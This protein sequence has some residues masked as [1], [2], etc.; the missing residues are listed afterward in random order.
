MA[1]AARSI[2][3]RPL[4]PQ[5]TPPRPNGHDCGCKGLPLTRPLEDLH[6]IRAFA[7]YRHEP[8]EI[9]GT[10]SEGLDRAAKLRRELRD[11]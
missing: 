3:A 11:R 6:E 8:A 2:L 7:Q 5:V 9:V 10:A 4:P 1:T